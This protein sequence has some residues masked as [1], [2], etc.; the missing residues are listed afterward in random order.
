[1][2]KK[3]QQLPPAKSSLPQTP[4]PIK[5]PK[6]TGSFVQYIQYIYTTFP[7]STNPATMEAILLQMFSSWCLSTANSSQGGKG[8][9]VLSQHFQ[10]HKLLQGNI[11]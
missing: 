1:M 8:Q 7:T 3:P 10:K 6:A 4:K 2:K 9:S 11:F 5:N